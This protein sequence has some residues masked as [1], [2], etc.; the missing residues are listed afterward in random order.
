[1]QNTAF[2]SALLGAAGMAALLSA[3][4]AQ[5]QAAGMLVVMDRC[6]M[7]DYTRFCD[8]KV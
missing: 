6:I 1:M 4:P 7:R 2:H 5:A 8:S 3:A